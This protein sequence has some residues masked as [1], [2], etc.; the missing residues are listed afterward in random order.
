MILSVTILLTSAKQCMFLYC[1]CA[2]S[3]VAYRV[4]NIL[5][6]M[7][8]SELTTCRGR[9]GLSCQSPPRITSLVHYY[10]LTCLPRC[11][12]FRAD[13]RKSALSQPCLRTY[14]FGL[15]I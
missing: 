2:V 15:R 1:L 9:I 5:R 6:T 12:T 4:V 7:N 3:L 13:N 8:F 11:T 14:R 10:C